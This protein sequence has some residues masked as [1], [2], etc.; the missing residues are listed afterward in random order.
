MPAE[1]TPSIIDHGY[2][3]LSGRQK[4]DFLFE[5]GIRATAYRD[6]EKPD[7][8]GGIVGFGD[9]AADSFH[10]QRL[11]ETLTRTD[12]EL[13]DPKRKLFHTFGSTA[14]IVFTPSAGT[15]YTGIF[16]QTAHGLARFSYAGPTHGVGIVPGLGLKF[17]LDGDHPSENLVVMR[18]LDRQEDNCVFRNPFTNILPTPRAT[19]VTMRVVKQRFETVVE[20]GRGLHQPVD[21][22]AAVSID[23]TAVAKV[24]APYRLIFKPAAHAPQCPHA[25][26]DFRDDLARNVK[27][28]T[29]IYD[30]F[31]L[32]ESDEKRLGTDDLDKL[33]PVAQKIGT[34]RTESEFIASAYGD[35]R[36]FFKH[37]AGFIRPGL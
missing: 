35:Y 36:L 3:K 1:G 25:K 26:I 30:V 7:I 13:E 16:A 5:R 6:N 22:L 18:M 33:L 29:T 27:S 17:P 21:N 9:S 23:G 14:K 32:D 4:R 31:A 19:N 8:R 20:D 2:A 37:N 11:K 10:H 24:N 34:I 28:G 15:P 12:D